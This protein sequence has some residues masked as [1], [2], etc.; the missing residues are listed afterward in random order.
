MNPEQPDDPTPRMLPVKRRGGCLRRL[1]IFALL[2]AIVLFVAA[3]Y[4][5]NL[6]SNATYLAFRQSKAPLEARRFRG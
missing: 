4:V 5:F 2:V 3:D 6:R 1:I